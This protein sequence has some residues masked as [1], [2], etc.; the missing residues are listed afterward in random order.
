MCNKLEYICKKTAV[1]HFKTVSWHFH[2]EMGKYSR[3]LLIRTL[4]I[5]IADYPD[6]LGPSCRFVKNSTKLFEITGNQIKYNIVLWFVEHHI[7]CGRKV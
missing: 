7:R 2:G 3:I 1:A 6:W 4:V 5:G